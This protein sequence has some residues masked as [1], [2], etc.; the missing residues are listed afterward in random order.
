MVRV[1]HVRLRMV[2]E[3]CW[4]GQGWGGGAVGKRRKIDQPFSGADCFPQF[5]QSSNKGDCFGGRIGR[6]LIPQMP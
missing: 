3:G 6:V 5:R 1:G 2:R 4:L